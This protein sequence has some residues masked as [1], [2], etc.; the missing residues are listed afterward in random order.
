[1]PW[2]FG[3]HKCSIWTRLRLSR[4]GNSRGPLWQIL[5]FR[6]AVVPP[7]HP[8]LVPI[9]TLA[10]PAPNRPPKTPEAPPLTTP[11]AILYLH[12][13]S[14]HLAWSLSSG[15][16]WCAP[17]CGTWLSPNTAVREV[18]S[19]PTP[20]AGQVPPALR[21]VSARTIFCGKPL[22]AHPAP[23]CGIPANHA[24]I[25]RR[26]LPACASAA[27]PRPNHNTITDRKA[28]TERRGGGRGLKLFQG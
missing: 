19:S 21:E 20:P 9:R 2:R 10:L 16:C 7:I 22:P 24:L 3:H 13:F 17:Q 28:G 23:H 12:T 15:H 18:I 4:S 26:L 11:L 1:M 27:I 5:L 25:T 6:C 8:L 14:V